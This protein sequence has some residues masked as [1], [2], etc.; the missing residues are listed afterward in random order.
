MKLIPCFCRTHVYMK[1]SRVVSFQSLKMYVMERARCSKHHTWTEHRHCHVQLRCKFSL[2][3][4]NHLIF[5]QCQL[6]TAQWWISA[7]SSWVYTDLTL[8][9]NNLLTKQSEKYIY[10]LNKF[11]YYPHCACIYKVL[12]YIIVNAS[13]SGTCLH[14]HT[15]WEG[16]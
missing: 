11:L 5:W 16:E 9:F 8:H 3:A 14:Q 7:W 15:E 4:F 12:M 10:F 1:C 6:M 13:K 2:S